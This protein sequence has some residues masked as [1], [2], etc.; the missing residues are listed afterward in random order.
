M[1]GQTTALPTDVEGLQRLVNSLQK[2]IAVLH[3]EL[4]LL[5]HKIFGRRSEGMTAGEETQSTLFDEAEMGHAAEA[6][7]NSEASVT[8]S[9]F[10]DN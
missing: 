5:R 1:G 3:D 2:E 7:E 10:S 4:K 6:A 8:V 9:V